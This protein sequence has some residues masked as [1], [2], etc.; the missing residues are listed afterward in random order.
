MEILLFLLWI[1][2]E[3]V[4]LFYVRELSFAVQCF[5]SSIRFLIWVWVYYI[6]IFDKHL[7]FNLI[8]LCKNGICEGTVDDILWPLVRAKMKVLGEVVEGNGCVDMTVHNMEDELVR[9]TIIFL[10][11]WFPF[12]LIFI[13]SSCTLLYDW[14]W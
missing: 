8:I 3:V 6:F 7:K 12:P 13:I 11:L 14:S 5:L 9:A 4:F 1:L 10:S 2:L